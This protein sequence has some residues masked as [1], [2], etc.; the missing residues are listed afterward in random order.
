[1]SSAGG[2]KVEVTDVA[3]WTVHSL[4]LLAQMWHQR[5]VT[6][7]R[8]SISTGICLYHLNQF[9]GLALPVPQVSSFYG[10]HLILKK[11]KATFLYYVAKSAVIWNILFGA[12]WRHCTD[13]LGAHF[14]PWWHRHRRAQ[15]L[16]KKALPRLALLREWNAKSA[17]FAVFTRPTFDPAI[18]DDAANSL[19]P[20]ALFAQLIWQ[21]IDRRRDPNSSVPRFIRRLFIVVK[22]SAILVHYRNVCH[23]DLC[24]RNVTA[25]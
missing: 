18:C 21:R 17:S 25:L 12:S 6:F 23:R 19:F 8:D 2:S 1:M 3:F 9:A 16:R 5:F 4:A 7:F 10:S 11:K 20:H 15:N 14:V 24:Y 13:G 22:F